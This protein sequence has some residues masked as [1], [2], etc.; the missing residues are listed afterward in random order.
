[1]AQKTRETLRLLDRDRA[2]ERRPSTRLLLENVVDDG[3]EFLAFG[4][5]DE[6]GLLDPFQRTIRRNDDDVE[7]VN[8]REFR[9]LCF[10]G[11]GHPR[12]L[13]VLAEVVLERDG[14]ERL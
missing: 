5:V 6:V 14:R 10:C 11:A 3:V 8:L 9:R 4:T 1:L 12:Q 2:D 7:V 13:A